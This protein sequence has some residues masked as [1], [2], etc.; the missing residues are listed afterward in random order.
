MEAG[1]E[2]SR[3]L[4]A[5]YSYFNQELLAG[6]VNKDGT[7]LAFVCDMMDQLRMAWAEAANSQA[8]PRSTAV[9]AGVNIAG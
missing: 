2:I 1:G 3:N 8:A 9:P 4:L 7:K 5:L 6:N